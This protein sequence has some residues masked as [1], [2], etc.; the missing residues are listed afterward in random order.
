MQEYCGYVPGVSLED[1]FEDRFVER[2]QDR[3]EY[4]D[5][6]LTWA[7]LSSIQRGTLREPVSKPV[8]MKK[9]FPR[10]SVVCW[11]G[12]MTKILASPV[13]RR[14]PV[15]FIAYN[16]DGCLL[17]C[18]YTNKDELHARTQN[19]TESERRS[20][21]TGY[22]FESYVTRQSSFSDSFYKPKF[23]TVSTSLKT[24]DFPSNCISFKLSGD[25][26]ATL[27]STTTT[28]CSSQPN[29]ALDTHS[30]CLR[31]DSYS[32][33]SALSEKKPFRL[34]WEGTCYGECIHECIGVS[35]EALKNAIVNT[36]Q[37]YCQVFRTAL[38]GI[39]ILSAGRIILA[40]YVARNFLRDK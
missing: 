4:L 16:L 26:C 32:D 1:G 31:L 33:T 17:L 34:D 30:P 40:I 11:R 22:R 19:I 2:P 20:S 35:D 38:G 5:H 9:L 39:T 36:N 18:E 24:K 6:L 27:V 3:P 23:P 7:V 13:E 21:Y 29:E 28:S 8:T 37:A 10:D 12:L 14:D 15:C 25:S